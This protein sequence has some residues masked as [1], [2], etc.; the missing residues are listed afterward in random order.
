MS[1]EDLQDKLARLE[2][3]LT[4]KPSDRALVITMNEKLEFECR[5]F[6][7]SYTATVGRAMVNAGLDDD[8][9]KIFKEKFTVDL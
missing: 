6:P 2:F 4:Y 1:C 5:R 3:K 7:S 8:K 9:L